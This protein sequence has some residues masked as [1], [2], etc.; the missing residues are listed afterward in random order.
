MQVRCPGRSRSCTARSYDVKAMS[1]TN[2]ISDNDVVS[3]TQ[4]LGYSLIL[5]GSNE[6]VNSIDFSKSVWPM[7]S[8][9]R[10]GQLSPPRHDQPDQ[11]GSRYEPRVAGLGGFRSDGP[12]TQSI[13]RETT[14]SSTMPASSISARTGSQGVTNE[15]ID[16]ASV[17]ANKSSAGSIFD[18][19]R[20]PGTDGHRP[21]PLRAGRLLRRQL[22]C[23]RPTSSQMPTLPHS[24]S[25]STA[26]A[27]NR[28]RPAATWLLTPRPSSMPAA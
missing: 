5:A 13:T 23:H 4:S 10:R 18:C 17:L 26:T 28:C 12:G 19:K 25:R 9:R 1:Q 14:R 8:D 21:R 22:S 20:L 2:Y 11:R 27:S 15:M 6:Q 7:G 16:L 24:C 3:Q